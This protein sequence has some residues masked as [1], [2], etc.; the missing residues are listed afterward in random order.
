VKSS[1][2]GRADDG[3]VAAFCCCPEDAPHFQRE[4][5]DYLRAA[6]LKRA[7]YVLGLRDEE[8][9]LVGISAFD[10]EPIPGPPVEP[11][12]EVRG[13]KLLAIGIDIE[14][15]RN[16]HSKT[17]LERTFETMFHL[18]ESRSLVIARAH[19]DNVASLTACAAAEIEV[20]PPKAGDYHR[21][22]GKVPGTSPPDWFGA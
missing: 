17:L 7:E 6:A 3:E 1:L 14:Q 10:P 19:V 20:Y 5:E 22:V 11:S 21:L 18:D 4:V 9:S 2:L 16:G 15:Q 13:W 12:I 8:G